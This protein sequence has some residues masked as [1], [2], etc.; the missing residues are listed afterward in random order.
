M[1]QLATMQNPVKEAFKL[2]Q[3]IWYDGLISISEFHRMIAQDGVRGATTNP[4]I[5]EK[6][7]SS[8]EYDE[9]IKG[10]AGEHEAAQIY[11]R[12]SVRAVQEVADV[13]MP[14]YKSSDGQD[15]FV[16]IEVS[17]LLAYDT[18]ATINE[19]KE[20]WGLVKRPNVMIKVPATAEGLP[21]VETLTAEGIPVNATLIFSTERYRQVMEAYIRGLEKRI[22][23]GQSIRECAS[24]ASF[25]V[26]RVD[27]AVDRQLEEKMSAVA[28]QDKGALRALL[29]KAGIAN[30][31]VAYEEFERI[32]LGGR[33]R[34]LKSKGGHLQKPVWASTGTKNPSYGDVFY[35]EALIGPHTVNTVPPSTLTSFLDHGTAEARL[36]QRTSEAREVLEKIR[37]Q[38]IELEQITRELESAGVAAFQDS[39]R[40]IIQRI[41]D[42]IHVGK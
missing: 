41:G 31:K 37:Q 3:S 13:F 30:S 7:L 4:A 2:G 9:A 14:V 17:P 28:E 18:A 38:G 34:Q 21:A 12:L 24:V 8:N 23:K 15:G 27:S 20:I 16:S 6:A 36:S 10:L 35:V 1:I 5:F 25:F 11:M 26:S 22:E 42:K 40:K 39:Y 33:F 19:A 29:G 32:F